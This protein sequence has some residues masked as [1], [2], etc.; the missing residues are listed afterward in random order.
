MPARTVRLYMQRLG[1]TPQ[2]PEKRTR[3]QKPEKVDRWMNRN[4][5]RIS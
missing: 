5:P 3:E 1:F 4:Y 2:R